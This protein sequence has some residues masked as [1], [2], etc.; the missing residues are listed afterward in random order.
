MPIQ[1]L[2][3]LLLFCLCHLAASAGN[4]LPPN[5]TGTWATGASLYEGATS[6]GELHLFSDG[7]GLMVGSSPPPKRTDGVDDGKPGPRVIMGFPVRVTQEKD[8]LLARPFQPGGKEDRE[9]AKITIYCHH[10]ASAASLTCK[11]PDGVA[12]PMKRR[13]ETVPDDVAKTMDTLR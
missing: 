8:V 6:Q 11:T 5:L 12:L 7:F 9:L 4:A 13:S 3:L 10:D 1:R 2:S